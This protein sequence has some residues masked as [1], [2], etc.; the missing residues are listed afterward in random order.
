VDFAALPP[1]D[2][3]LISHDHYDHLDRPT[4]LRLAERYPAARWFCPSGVEPWLR[5]RGVRDVVERGWWGSTDWPADGG[6]VTCVPARHFSGRR[7]DTRDATLWCGWVVRIGGRS[8]YF[9]GDSGRHP[10]FG[11]IGRRLGPF[12]AVLMPIGAY[13]PEWFMEA[14][15]MNPEDAVG[16][17]GD[18]IART[19]A[20]RPLLVGM[21]WGTF[22]LT[23]EPMDE[24]ASRTRSAWADAGRATEGL[25]IPRHGETRRV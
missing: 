18:V 17:Y 10:E 5:A 20:V 2:A 1:I 12:D 16:A 9:V 8:V 11:E 24:P 14:V 25:W 19:S 23:D 15:H 7:L 4:V 6:T 3:V 21:H 22:Q 13:D